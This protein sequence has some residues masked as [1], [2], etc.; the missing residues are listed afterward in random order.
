MWPFNNQTEPILLLSYPLMY[1]NLHIQHGINLI[2]ILLNSRE[3]NEISADT[4]ADTDVVIKTIISLEYIRMG[5]VKSVTII[6]LVP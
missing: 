3:N 1:I 2:I 4:V 6:F 5:K